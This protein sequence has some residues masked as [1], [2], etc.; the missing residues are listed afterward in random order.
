MT[1]ESVKNP[2]DIATASIYY[3]FVLRFY[4]PVNPMGSMYCFINMYYVLQRKI[5]QYNRAKMALYCSTDYQTSFE[6]T[7]LSVQEKKFNIDFQDG[8]HL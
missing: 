3:L 1:E 7:D 2:L 8:G 4:G 5:I 6:S